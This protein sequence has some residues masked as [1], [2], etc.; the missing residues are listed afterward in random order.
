M[1][2]CKRIGLARR[3]MEILV[4][5]SGVPGMRFAPSGLLTPLAEQVVKNTPMKNGVG[6]LATIDQCAEVGVNYRC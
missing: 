3:M 6:C 1:E 5:D 2:R 4:S